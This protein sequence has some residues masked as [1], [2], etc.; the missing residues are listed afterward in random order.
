MRGRRIKSFVTAGLKSFFREKSGVFW[1]LAWPVILLLLTAFV[2]TAPSQSGLTL[3]VGVVNYDESNTPFNGSSLIHVMDSIVVNGTK[4][5]N[6]RLYSNETSLI[7]DLKKNKIDVGI[8][9]PEGFGKSVLLGQAR[10]KVMV[11]GGST[12]ELQVNKAVIMSF[13]NK[14]ATEIALNKINVSL[15]YFKLYY[16]SNATITLPWGNESLYS[17]VKEFMYGLA[18]P[19][20]TTVETVAPKALVNRAFLL[21]WYAFGAIGMVMLYG[22]FIFGALTVTEELPGDRLRRILSTPVT[23]TEFLVGKTISYLIILFLSALVTIAVALGL[24]ARFTWSLSNPADWLV[25]LHLLLIALMTIGIGFILSLATKSAKA[26]SSLGTILGL[27]LSFIAGIW[28]PKTWL[29]APLKALANSFPVTWSLD[30]VRDVVLKGA[31]VGDIAFVT[32][33][34]IIAT[35]AILFIGV[36]SYKKVLRRYIEL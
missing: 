16:P 29:P 18:A 9:I 1:I 3:K 2:F 20:N 31:G 13:I 21:G 19:I 8:V 22:G 14:L 15:R 11:S 35:I 33:K 4:M 24:G 7:N 6:V 23:E 32:V 27:M 12:Y 5:F 26:A 10:L 30:A 17:F 28:F 25:M 34:C 36:L